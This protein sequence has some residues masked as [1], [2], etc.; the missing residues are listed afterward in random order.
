MSFEERL[1][2][3]EAERA[4]RKEALASQRKEQR[5]E[6]LEAL[7]ALEIEKGDDAV[8]AVEIKRYS[9]G[10][11]TLVVVRALTPAELKR[12]RDQVSRGEDKVTPAEVAARAARLYPDADVWSEIDRRFPG[13]AVRAG[14][15]AVELSAALERA[16]GN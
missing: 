8:A 5:V 14:V 10:L 7:N 11:P 12:Y 9:P 1:S 3:V 16:E 13:F 2:K 15:Q 6:D 4:A